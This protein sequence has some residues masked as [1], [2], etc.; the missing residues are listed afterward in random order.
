[1]TQELTSIIESAWDS[2]DQWNAKTIAADQ[3]EA[4]MSVLAGLNNGSM[5]V[6]EKTAE[7]WL[8]H[9]WIK[10]AV[11]LSFRLMPNEVM[12]AG[13][14]TWYDK[15]PMKFHDNDG[16]K[17]AESGIRAIFARKGGQVVETNLAAFRAGYEAAQKQTKP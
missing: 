3:R 6:A 1:M 13:P 4:I 11:L 17:I 15:L 5:R 16:Q 8:T 12:K 10:K 7:G 2:R 9:Q 14:F